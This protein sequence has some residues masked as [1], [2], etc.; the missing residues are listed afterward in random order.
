MNKK[1]GALWR[2]QMKDGKTYFTGTIEIVAGTQTKIVLF[3]N[4]IKNLPAS[5]NN[6]ANKPAY[7]I[8]LSEP[9]N[10]KTVAP[11][12]APEVTTEKISD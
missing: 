10:D 6:A 2:H 12:K 4:E 3:P 11:I 1:L 8:Y 5:R 9:R 7:N